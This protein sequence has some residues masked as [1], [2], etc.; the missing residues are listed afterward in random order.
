MRE[1][2]ATLTFRDVEQVSTLLGLVRSGLDECHEQLSESDRM[3]LSAEETEWF[4][5]R[6]KVLRGLER[7]LNAAGLKITR[8][9]R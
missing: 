2:K 3:S 9:D 8:G 1:R 6:A 4:T 7:R 5:R